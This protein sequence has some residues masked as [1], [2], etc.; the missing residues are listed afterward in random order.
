MTGGFNRKNQLAVLAKAVLLLLE[1]RT[2][3]S[4][5]GSVLWEDLNKVR[6]E[7]MDLIGIGSL[8][9]LDEHIQLSGRVGYWN[10]RLSEASR[11]NIDE[12]Q[13]VLIQAVDSLDESEIFPSLSAALNDIAWAKKV[14]EAREG[15]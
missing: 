1:D 9:R 6:C 11:G 14:I 7:I 10:V 4:E 8:A 15:K 12:Y 5:E 2:K 3:K 13:K